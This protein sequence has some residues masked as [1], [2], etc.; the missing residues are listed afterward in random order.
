VTADA[1]RSPLQTIG[2]T[3]SAAGNEMLTLSE[4][5]F[6]AQLDIRADPTVPGLIETLGRVAGVDLPT[7]PN[8]VTGTASLAA[9]WLGPDEW[10]LVAEGADERRMAALEA[11]ARANAGSVVDVSAGRTTVELAGSLARSLL[12]EGCS[13]DLHPRSFRS[14][15]CAQTLVGRVS[16]ILW[17]VTDEP[18]YRLLVRPS[19]AR[20]LARWLVDALDGVA[21]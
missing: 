8:S 1:R 19:F 15:S 16:V 5:P 4:I 3:L 2:G 7:T 18:R 10:L 21:V 11:V 9:L 13:I 12:E 17:Q 20:H 14:G 6:L